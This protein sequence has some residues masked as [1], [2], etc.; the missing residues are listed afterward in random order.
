M[1]W[2][3]FREYTIHFLVILSWKLYVPTVICIAALFGFF[4]AVTYLQQVEHRSCEKIPL[5]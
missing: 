1:R 2:H 3:G 5:F 4:F